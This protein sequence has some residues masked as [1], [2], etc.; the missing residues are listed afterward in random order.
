MANYIELF[1][2]IFEIYFWEESMAHI[3]G[4]GLPPRHK[5]CL[6]VG[7]KGRGGGSA[8][9]TQAKTT[10]SQLQLVEGSYWEKPGTATGLE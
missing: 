3:P 6:Y 1:W 8:M 9:N 5:N 7:P 2:E 10:A 4:L